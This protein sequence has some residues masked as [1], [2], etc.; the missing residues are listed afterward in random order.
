MTFKKLERRGRP[1]N[2]ESFGTGFR[3]SF[4]HSDEHKFR[5]DG[6]KLVPRRLPLASPVSG[7]NYV[8]CRLVP[9][10]DIQLSEALFEWAAAWSD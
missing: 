7:D 9:R 3:E 10:R 6:L 1:P 5:F 2:D 8:R 4:P